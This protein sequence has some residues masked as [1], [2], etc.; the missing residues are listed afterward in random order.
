MRV[1]ALSLLRPWPIRDGT[2]LR[3]ASIARALSRL[4][5]LTVI[6]PAPAAEEPDGAVPPGITVHPFA[7]RPVGRPSPLTYWRKDVW[8][9]HLDPQPLTDAA[10]QVAGRHRFQAVICWA[11]AELSAWSAFGSAA[12]FDVTDCRSLTQWRQAR[13]GRTWRERLAGVKDAMLLSAY[14]R[15]VMPRHRVILVAG[16]DDARVIKRIARGRRIEVLANGVDTGFFAPRAGTRSARPT[17]VFSGTLDYAPNVDAACFLADRIWPAVRAVVPD[18]RL[19]IVGE[20]PAAPVRALTRH[21]G[22]EVVGSVP[23]IREP[24]GAAWVG[25]APMRSGAG[26]KNKVLEAWAMGLPVVMTS[27]AAS[28]LEASAATAA[29]VTDDPRGFAE[30]VATL[31]RAPEQRRRLGQAARDTVVSRHTWDEVGARLRDI[32]IHDCGEG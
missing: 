7:A 21:P 31:L 1:L 2:S 4:V 10:E 25:V 6:C 17:V 18:A 20:R 28:G 3:R 14:E 5:D 12:C 13:Y 15:L 22:I 24:L 26:V 16:S 29:V 23:D 27:R 9:F 19:M 30:A 32:L 11:G 8:P